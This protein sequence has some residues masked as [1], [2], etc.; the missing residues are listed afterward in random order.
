MRRPFATVVGV[1][2][3]AAGMLWSGSSYLL[4]Q[5]EHAA[6]L[7]H[8]THEYRSALD[9]IEDHRRLA[10]D[11]GPWLLMIGGL[12]PL[13]AIYGG[14]YLREKLSRRSLEIV[15]DGE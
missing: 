7:F 10:V 8:M 13:L 5:A 1:A 3:L 2:S 9:W 14:P 4:D 6:T 11:Y 12:S 15:F